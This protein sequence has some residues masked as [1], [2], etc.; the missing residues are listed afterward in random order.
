MLA[1]G[2]TCD[3]LLEAAHVTQGLALAIRG[4][5]E[6]ECFQPAPLTELAELLENKIADMRADLVSAIADAGGNA[7]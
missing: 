7:S 6:L 5:A 3:R 1:A 4:A 2:R